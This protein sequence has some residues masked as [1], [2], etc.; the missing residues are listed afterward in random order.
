LGNSSPITGS[1]LL[2]FYYFFFFSR[3]D[4]CLQQERRLVPQNEFSHISHV[5]EAKVVEDIKEEKKL[6]LNNK[7]EKKKTPFPQALY[8]EY[9]KDKKGVLWDNRHKD[10]GDVCGKIINK[11]EVDDNGATYSSFGGKTLKRLRARSRFVRKGDLIAFPIDG[12]TEWPF[13]VARVMVST[14]H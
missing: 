11:W 2:G 3:K 8:D 6:P 7:E 4:Q 13:Y 5:H 9:L 14:D 10:W 12:D 1:S